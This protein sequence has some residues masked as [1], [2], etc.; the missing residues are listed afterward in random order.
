MGNHPSSRTVGGVLTALTHIVPPGALG[1]LF[2]AF[3]APPFDALRLGP[4]RLGLYG[5]MI[6][7]GAL[8]AV[9][10][11]GS[12]LESSGVGSRDDASSIA[13]IALPAGVIGSRVYHVVTD[14]QDYVDHPLAALQF[15]KGG[16]GI[17]GGIAGG[18][19]A[20]VLV[21]RRRGLDAAAAVTAV[22]PALPLAQAFG[23]WGNWFNQE[24][25]GRPTRLPWGLE[26][27]APHRPP[28]LP[29]DTLFHPTFLYESLGC[30]ALT[31]LLLAVDRRVRLR[32]GRLLLVYVSGYTLLRFPVESLRIDPAPIWVGLRLSQWVALT[33]FILAASLLLREYRRTDRSR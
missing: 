25:Y 20:G 5:V 11:F 9:R 7:V 27:T 13:T 21:A 28:G 6:G 8:L 24:L 26:V 23:R 15:W 12:R 3:P 4:V 30:L 22:V 18:I 19:I 32:P 17:W 14:W 16:L 33:L 31:A 10:L 1:G 2:A 29:P